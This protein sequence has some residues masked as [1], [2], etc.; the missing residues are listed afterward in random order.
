MRVTIQRFRVVLLAVS[1]RVIDWYPL[2]L[3]C[4]TSNIKTM[5]MGHMSI[6]F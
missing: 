6:L 2:G 4:V 1:S 5:F 3:L